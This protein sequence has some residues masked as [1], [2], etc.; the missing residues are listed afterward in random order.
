KLN[1]MV[2]AS[3]TIDNVNRATVDYGKR[4]IEHFYELKLLDRDTSIIHSVWLSERELELIKKSGSS[5]IHAPI[6]NILLAY[7]IAPVERMVSMGINVALG[8]DGLASYTQDMFQVLRIAGLLQKIHTLNAESLKAYELLE[9]ATINGAKA[10]GLESEIGSIEVG[11]KADI[12][13]VDLKKPHTHP[14]HN[15]IPLL[16]YSATG[17]DVETVI[18]DGKIIMEDRIVKTLDESEVLEKAQE[19]SE[20]LIKKLD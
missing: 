13:I 19:A 17:L 7:G 2:H 5:I 12:I 8:T 16:A 15:V 14:L 20:N 9:M 4:E 10:L 18:V 6:C 1:Y 11:K 3:A